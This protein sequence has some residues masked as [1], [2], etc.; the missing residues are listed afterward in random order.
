MKLPELK[1]NDGDHYALLIRHAERG[2]VKPNESGNGINLT[3]NGK[4]QSFKLGE[5]MKETLG[6]IYAS[7]IIRCVQTASW[8]VYGSGTNRK[9]TTSRKLGDPGV[10]IENDQTAFKSF[11][12]L[13]IHE[14]IKRLIKM[15]SV[16]GMKDFKTGFNDLL[17]FISTELK[18][19]NEKIPVFVSH[20]AVIAPLI[21]FS[22]KTTDP[23]IIFPEFL[24]GTVISSNSYGYK[25]YWRGKWYPLRYPD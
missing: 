1:K 21:G 2:E 12:D 6:N 18:T 7:P 14:L 19:H 11:I 22:L 5:E 9:I 3:V 15:E 13:G 16:P 20:D 25:I 23:D 10:W 17:N 24:E 8:I 4:H